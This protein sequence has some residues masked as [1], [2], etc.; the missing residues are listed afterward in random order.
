M[1]GYMLMLDGTYPNT[2]KGLKT[3]DPL[4]PDGKLKWATSGRATPL[5]G[6][7]TFYAWRHVFFPVLEKV[8][9]SIVLVNADADV[10]RLLAVDLI[11]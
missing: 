3:M 11:V 2:S 4:A 7:W 8:M 5:F 10:D 1:I 9:G 6:W